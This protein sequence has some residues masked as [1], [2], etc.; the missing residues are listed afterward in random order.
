MNNAKKGT[1]YPNRNVNAKVDK[2]NNEEQ[3]NAIM[4]THGLGVQ[5]ARGQH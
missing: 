5:N 3:L 1:I 4:W 2:I